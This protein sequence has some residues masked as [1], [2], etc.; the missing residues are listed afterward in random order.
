MQYVQPQDLRKFG[1]IPELIGRLPVVT[2]LHPLDREALRN[3][4][5]EPKNSLIR[6]QKKLFK[7]DGVELDFTDDALE[8]MVD[9]AVERGLGARGLRGI[10]EAVMTDL[11]FST[12]GTD[13][14]KINITGDY[15][16]EQL[17]KSEVL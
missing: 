11:Q 1:L 7:M 5:T 6:Q 2:Y 9:K 17:K 14:K 3:I 10:V 12:P 16:R 8:A 13:C 15:V 4:L